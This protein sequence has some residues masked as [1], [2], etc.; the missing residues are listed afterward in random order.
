MN[1]VL[2]INL[3]VK[4]FQIFTILLPPTSP[5]IPSHTI[6]MEGG[7]LSSLLHYFNA[8]SDFLLPK[9]ISRR[10]SCEERTIIFW[11]IFAPCCAP[12]LPPYLPK[13]LL[14]LITLSPPSSFLSHFV[15]MIFSGKGKL[16]TVVSMGLWLNVRGRD[17]I[18]LLSSVI[19]AGQPGQVQRSAEQMMEGRD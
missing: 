3:F 6:S 18:I 5:G 19:A 8:C 7:I 9:G 15:F 10:N 17:V 16:I 2:E 13:H 1:N 12:S 14:L 11:S 4:T